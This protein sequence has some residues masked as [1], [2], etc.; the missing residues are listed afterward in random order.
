MGKVPQASA[1]ERRRIPYISLGPRLDTGF[2]FDLGTQEPFIRHYFLR[3]SMHCTY[4]RL[5]PANLKK[6]RVPDP[7]FL[8]ILKK[9]KKNENPQEIL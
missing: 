5:D 4:G 1:P 2:T 8:K 3:F 7:R 6:L 9:L